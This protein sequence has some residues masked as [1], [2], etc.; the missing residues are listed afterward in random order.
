MKIA[1]CIAGQPRSWEKGYEYLKKNL[2]DHFDCDV[3]FHSWSTASHQKIIDLYK[4]VSFSF[5]RPFPDFI[6]DNIN[7]TYRNDTID[8]K[9]W[10]CSSII[11]SFYSIAQV[12][13]KLTYQEVIHGKKYDWVVKTRFDYALNRVLPFDKLSRRRE[14]FIPNCRMTAERN[15]GNDQFAFG[16]PEVM[17]EYMST[18]HYIKNFYDR[19]VKLI[20]EDMLSANLTRAGLIGNN[21]VYVDMHNPFPPGP[22]NGTWHSLIRDDVQLWQN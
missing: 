17:H 8:P 14:V 10:P 16:I 13:A 9:K 4:P 19:G 7:K 3:L 15:F 1:V 20:G 11:S 2:L 22:H 5:E 21:L 6:I 12:N 18:F